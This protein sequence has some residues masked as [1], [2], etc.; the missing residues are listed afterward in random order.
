[1]NVLDNRALSQQA[2]DWY[3]RMP[4]E[5]KHTQSDRR[6]FLRWLKAARRNVE[7]LLHICCV[8]EIFSRTDLRAHLPAVALTALLSNALASAASGDHSFT[9]GSSPPLHSPAPSSLVL[10]SGIVPLERTDQGDIICADQVQF[11]RIA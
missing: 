10:D 2:A 1:M 3:L 7:A 11:A 6:R 5:T 4:R 9:A 8:D